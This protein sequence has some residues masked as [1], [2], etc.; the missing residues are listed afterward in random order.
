MKKRIVATLLAAFIFVGTIPAMAAGSL[1]NF[2]KVNNYTDKTFS[3]VNSNN[4]FADNVRKSYELGLFLGIGGNKF[5][6]RG[7]ISVIQ[8]ITVA[9]RIHK[10]YNEGNADFEKTTPWHT[11]YM[12]YAVKNGIVKSGEFT[13]LENSATRAQFAYILANAL[14]TS[15]YNKINSISKGEIP[16]VSGSEYF[17][18]AVYALYNAGIIIGSD[19]YGTF[20]PN[21]P[22]E[23]SAVAAIAARM[24][25]KNVR[26]KAALKPS[27]VRVG[28]D[29]FSV[30]FP[31]SWRDICNVSLSGDS[32]T[33][34]E[35]SS[36][37]TVYGGR[38]Y[39]IFATDD[40]DR[41]E[42]GGE[43]GR[44]IG[45]IITADG[46]SLQVYIQYPSDVQFDYENTDT[47]AR[48]M[49]ISN[50]S[51]WVLSTLAPTNGGVFKTEGKYTSWRDA[52][53]DQLQYMRQSNKDYAAGSGADMDYQEY[54]LYDIDK[55]GTPEMFVKFG[56]C[57]ADFEWYIY[58]FYED[59]GCADYFAVLDGG[60]R[61]I[62]GVDGEN[63]FYMHYGHLGFEM[64]TKYT[65]TGPNLTESNV[66]DG[67]FETE[68]YAPVKQID[69]VDIN[70]DAGL[71]WTANNDG[72]NRN[73]A[74]NL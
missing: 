4:W 33:F 50:G 54:G 59:L 35:K 40:P 15:E 61:V 65:L 69:S 53:Y 16:D 38:V 41:I 13:N 36:Q 24:A 10:I 20:A 62:C 28:T 63:A 32:I 8:T 22:I 49:K 55:D 12:D 74:E 6:P 37:N 64:I 47:A 18:E 51:N 19:D 23:R 2:K 70:S 11:A 27:Y 1:S 42:L 71:D 46:K 39:T 58:K 7:D 25:D 31:A 66:Y 72:G 21:T 56:S 43:F 52:Y 73:I 67:K 48:Y 5:V 57:E 68:N 45:T 34:F 29:N 26:L 30:A 9:C 14:P 44:K 60:H 17:D 3:D